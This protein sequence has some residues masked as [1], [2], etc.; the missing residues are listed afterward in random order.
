MK[1]LTILLAFMLSSCAHA[2]PQAL[3]NTGTIDTV[4]GTDPAKAVANGGD[5]WYA[6]SFPAIEGTR[7][8]CCWKGNWNSGNEAGCSL[9][10]DHHSYGTR[11]D[12]PLES[13]II[14][15]TRVSN[16]EVSAMKVIGEQCPMDA[17]GQPVNW[18]PGADTAA[19]LDWLESLAREGKEDRVGHSALWALSLHASEKAGYRLY[20]LATDEH[21][22]RSAEAIFWLGEARGHAGF[23]LLEDLL[24][25]LPAGETRRQI[26]FALSQNDSQEAAVLLGDIARNDRDPEQRADALFWLAQEYP[27]TAEVLI[28]EVI[29]NETDS[30]ALEKAVFAI[31]QLPSGTSGPMLLELAGDPDAPRAA[32][33]QALF[34][35]AHS[36]DDQAVSE[37]AELLSR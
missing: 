12:S 16:G 26:N 19:T 21:S 31:S 24:D 7:S 13:T 17:A 27:E 20:A 6:F 18:M 9:A 5:G 15:Y 22:E 23:E 14:A 28:R 35:L 32:R 30:E 29:E 2:Q 36:D 4:I 33:R 37:L 25:E 34:W 11:S 10:K 8:P 1:Q 3:S